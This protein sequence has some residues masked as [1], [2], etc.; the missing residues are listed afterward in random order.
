MNVCLHKKGC[1]T[2]RTSRMTRVNLRR[3]TRRQSTCGLPKSLKRSQV[4][5]IQ[6]FLAA[7]SISLSLNCAC[8][9]GAEAAN[10]STLGRGNNQ[11][12]SACSVRMSFDS[13]THGP[14]TRLFQKWQRYKS[15]FQSSKILWA[16]RQPNFS[17][18]AAQMPLHFVK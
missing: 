11:S 12:C 15:R 8:V 1:K 2:T 4:A 5:R 18:F 6:T 9:T 10:W 13:S 17:F 7:E 16:A 3:A 14:C